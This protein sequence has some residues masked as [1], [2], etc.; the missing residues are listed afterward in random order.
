[1]NLNIV[2]MENVWV[3]IIQRYPCEKNNMIEM[4]LYDLS[5]HRLAN[6]FLSFLP[7]S[8]S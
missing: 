6:S 7:L 3:Y 1:M 5:I 2:N 4:M 8:S